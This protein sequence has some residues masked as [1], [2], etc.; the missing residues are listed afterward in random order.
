M[1]DELHLHLTGEARRLVDVRRAIREWLSTQHVDRLED[2]VLA[3]DEA[4]SNAIE[5]SGQ[6]R[7]EPVV[8]DV[9]ARN[10]GQSICVEVT[11]AGSWRPRRDDDTRGRGLNIIGA[12]MDRVQVDSTGRGTC[13]TM[14]R[15]IE[16]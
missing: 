3:V 9:V 15:S 8:I 12:L 2:V 4:V 1:V 11:D 5:H 13:V 10:D 7:V 16:R 14:Y 6:F